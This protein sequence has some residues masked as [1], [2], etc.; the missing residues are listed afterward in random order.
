[1]QE[2]AEAWKARVDDLGFRV[3]RVQGLGCIGFSVQRLGFTGVRVFGFV[4]CRV[5]PIPT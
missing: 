3:Y 5:F 2:A 1:M 4:G